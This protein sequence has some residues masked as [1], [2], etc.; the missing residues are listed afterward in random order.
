M[1][2]S[3]VFCTQ[4]FNNIYFIDIL[5][6]WVF[7]LFLLDLSLHTLSPWGYNGALIYTLYLFSWGSRCIQFSFP[8]NRSVIASQR[9]WLA[10][11]SCSCLRVAFLVDNFLWCSCP[12]I[13]LWASSF[14][15]FWFL[16]LFTLLSPLLRPEWRT[17]RLLD[18]FRVKN[19]NIKASSMYLT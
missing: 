17:G 2:H 14:S 15:M 11:R 3:G 9:S 8:N 18:E 7:L 4:G 5:H 16:G 10:L 6:R 12:Y 19:R 13:L 1:I